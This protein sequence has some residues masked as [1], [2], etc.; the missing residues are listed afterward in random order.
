[1]NDSDKNTPLQTSDLTKVRNAVLAATWPQST[2]TPTVTNPGVR[3][4]FR[5]LMMFTHNAKKECEVAFYR[6]DPSHHLD[7]RIFRT[8]GAGK[9]QQIFQTTD[10]VNPVTMKTISVAIDGQET[11]A[12]AQFFH[13]IG[14]NRESGAGDAKDFRWLL[15]L[16]SYYGALEKNTPFFRTKAQVSHGVFYT[17]QRTN[18]KFNGKG[19][20]FSSAGDPLTYIAK[21]MAADIP[22]TFGQSVSLMIN[23]HPVFHPLVLKD[24]YKYE[25]HFNNDCLTAEGKP[26][27]DSDFHL[28]FGAT[29]IAAGDRFQLEPI[30]EKPDTAPQ[31]I[32]NSQDYQKEGTD[33]APCVG[34]GFGQGGGFPDPT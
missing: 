18:S 16:E 19:G 30:M 14:F 34:G 1:M 21:I 26:C 7:I 27:P 5:G 20:P 24:G 32:C 6:S 15:D 10:E 13:G 31:G 25:I 29:K 4:V 22:L 33:R 3:L 9:C 28:A 17:Y 12:N 23:N 2:Q 8:S 11:N